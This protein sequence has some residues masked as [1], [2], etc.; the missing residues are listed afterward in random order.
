M[1]ESSG[2]CGAPFTPPKSFRLPEGVGVGEPFDMVCTFEST[3]NGKLRMTK[4]GDT[5]I[6]TKEYESEETPKSK[7][8]YEQYAQGIMGGMQQSGMAEEA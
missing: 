2:N 8:N 6:E 5:E 3:E 4:L 1:N 7:P